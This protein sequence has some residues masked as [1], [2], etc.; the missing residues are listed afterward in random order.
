MVIFHSYVAFYQRVNG[1]EAVSV[2]LSKEEP[3][4]KLLWWNV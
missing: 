1:E 4:Q 2:S 3:A